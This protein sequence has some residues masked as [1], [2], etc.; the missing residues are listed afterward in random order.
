MAQKK[1]CAFVS[2][3]AGDGDPVEGMQERLYPGKLQ[4]VFDTIKPAETTAFH[5][6][7][8]LTKLSGFENWVME[9]LKA[10]EGDFR[11]RNAI[12]TRVKG[13]AKQLRAT[14]INPHLVRQMNQNSLIRLM[15]LFLL[16]ILFLSLFSR[17]CHC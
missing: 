12:S 8:D 16:I 15:F 11:N 6:N 17:I 10:P 5:G 7:V 13:I 4:F 3:P 1:V 14:L 9:K 2:G